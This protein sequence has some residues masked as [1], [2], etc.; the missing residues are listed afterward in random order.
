MRV[1][2]ANQSNIDASS[3]TNL[4]LNSMELDSSTSHGILGNNIT[5]LTING[6]TFHRGGAD[7]EPTCNLHG[8]EITNLLGTS[9]VTGAAFTRSNTIQFHV[10]N[11]TMASAP[12]TLT[13]SGTTWAT[14]DGPCSGDHLSVASD[15]GGNFKLVVNSSTGIN[16]VNEGGAA[17]TGGGIGVQA[18]A[19]GSGTMQASVTGLKTTNNTAGVAVAASAT[20]NISFNVFNNTTANGT[21]F[22]S[23]GSVALILTCTTTGTCQGAFTNNSITHTAGTATN[24]MQ[25]VVEGNG[26]GIVTVANNIVSGDFQRGL[27]AQSRAGSGS[28]SLHATGNNFTQTDAA[29]LQVMNLE[30]G[31]SGGGTTNSMCLNLANNISTP[32]GANSAY[33]LLHRTGYT[34]QLQNLVQASTTNTADVETWVTTTKSNTGT[35][36]GVS[37]GTT[38]FTTSAGCATPTLP[39]P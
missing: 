33:R 39:S 20:S 30:V 9:S 19:Q 25:V 22:S 26:T 12:D 31:A 36:V 7:G 35:P 16:T 14:H 8:V 18:A 28:L 24:A 6:G 1:F 3:V 29:G 11:S 23:T 38:A 5:N 13:V 15:T 34:F 4:T 21:G 27:H 17:S 37:I 32:A 10:V 2:S